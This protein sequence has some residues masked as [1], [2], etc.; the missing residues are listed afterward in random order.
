M[1]NDDLKLIEAARE[2][3]KQAYSPYS[4]YKVG[5]ALK[6]VKGRIYSG[7]N[8]ENASYGLSLCAERNALTHAVFEGEKN[9]QAIAIFVDAEQLFPPCGACRQVL[10]EFS[11]GMRVI[12]ANRNEVRTALLN[13]LLPESFQL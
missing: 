1:K 7:C 13:E 10:S 12:Y 8:V 4:K 3:A 2:A 9:F 6:S 11:P 5:A